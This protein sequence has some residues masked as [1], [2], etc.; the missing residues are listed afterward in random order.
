MRGREDVVG[1]DHQHP[2]LGLS[3]RRERQVHG[4]LVAVEVRVERVADQRVDLDRLALDEHRLERLDAEPVERRRAVQQHRVLRDHLLED[5]PDLGHHRLDHLLGGLDVLDRLALD[6]PAHD[7]RLEQLERHELRQ[8]ALVELHVRAGHDDRAARVVH[9]LAEQVLPEP[10]LLALEHVGERLQGAVARAGHGSSAAP[11]VEQ[12]VDRL[13]EHPLLVVDDDLGRPEVEQALQAVVPVDHAPVEIVEVARREAAAVELNHRAQL[14][15]DDRDGVEDHPLGAILRLDECADDLQ[16]LDRALL[17]LP[18][19]RRDDPPEVVRLLLERE[20]LQQVADRLRAHAA[21]EVDA[22]PVGRP[23]PILHLAEGQL[24]VDDLLRLELA[25]PRPGL[26]EPAPRVVGGLPRVAATGVDVEVHLAD[27]EGPLDGRVEIVLLRPRLGLEAEVVGELADL[28]GR[29][30][31]QRLEKLAEQARPDLARLLE[32]LHVDRRRALGVLALEPG[33]AEQRLLKPL[34]VLR[35]RTLLRAGRGLRVGDE[36]RER[37]PK[38]YRD[39]RDE[40]ELARGEVAIRP[41]RRLADELPRLLGVLR[42]DGL[43]GVHEDPA[44]ELAGLVERGQ[45]LLLGPVR[46][47]AGPELVV[48]VEVLLLALREVLPAPREPLLEGCELLVAIDEDPLGLGQDLVPEIGEVGHPLVAVDAR[49]DGRGEVENL[50]E[51]LGRDVEEVAD[52]ARDALEEPDV[53]DGC[54]EVDVAH[55]LAANLLAR[56]LDTA[57]L[58]DDALVA[59]ALVLPAV[60]LPVL[61]G[62]EDTLAEQAVLLGLQ[63]AVVDRLRLRDLAGRPVAD[64]LRRRE[65]DPDRVEVVDVDQGVS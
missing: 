13:L 31:R 55:A 24:V 65:P 6:E 15:R 44:D 5:V 40:V 4:H 19:R 41:G 7:E 47:A 64:L 42:R 2:R 20:I 57:P 30:T 12:G 11:V 8:P 63:G 29:L 46:E 34:D 60:A 16:A 37:V 52:P 22:E 36:R 14:G 49:H 28:L 23:E 17:L 62:T 39:L 1:G 53:G 35:D 50:L 18:L 26:L 21:L 27:L 10:P 54:R 33:A 59:D 56:D 58:A 25:E 3:L 48:L 38:L 61:R 43:R 9:A 45:P 51:L 32:A